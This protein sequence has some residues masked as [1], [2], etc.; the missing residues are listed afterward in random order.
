MMFKKIIE[1][2]F[3][4]NGL[5]CVCT[6]SSQGIRCGYVGVDKSHPWWGMNCEDEGPDDVQ[7]HWGLTYSGKLLEDDDRWFFGFDAG[8]CTDAIDAEAVEAYNLAEGKQLEML[9]R[10]AEL[11]NRRGTILKDTEFMV[12]I[13]KLIAEQ[14][15]RVR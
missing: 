5:L 2:Q 11:Y 14:L 10:T 8:H 9:K 12:E 15:I 1:K 6:L 7:C 13:C 3:D 4:H